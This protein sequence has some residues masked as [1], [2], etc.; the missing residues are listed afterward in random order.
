MD[1]Y[2]RNVGAIDRGAIS[3]MIE[4]LEGHD[5]ASI[6]FQDIAK[7]LGWIDQ[8]HAIPGAWL[9]HTQCRY[10]EA[11]GPAVHMGSAMV[12][13]R[14]LFDGVDY[15]VTRQRDRSVAFLHTAAGGRG[16]GGTDA[17]A[18]L[19]AVLRAFLRSPAAD[20]P[21]VEI[22]DENYGVPGMPRSS[23]EAPIGRVGAR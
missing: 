18:L 8:R 23:T 12:F 7:P 19:G 2:F 10:C 1:R 14:A 20:A 11:P 6:A 3:A 9:S 17:A 22:L 13:Y 21:P 15:S 5:L 4:L 16:T